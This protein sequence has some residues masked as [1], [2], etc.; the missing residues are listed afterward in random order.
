M[1]IDGAVVIRTYSS[2]AAANVAA[3]ILG[4]EGIETHIQK[5]DCGG[6]YPS[7]QMS[8]GVRLLVKPE[9]REVADRILRE[10]ESEESLQTEPPES[11]EDLERTKSSPFVVAGW[12]ILG[13]AIGFFVSFELLQRSGYN[14]TMKESYNAVG[15]P[16]RIV[17]YADGK[18]SRYEEDRNYDGKVDAWYTFTA[19]QPRTGTL[20]NN[21][22]GKP[23]VWIM[24]KDEFNYTE[25]MDTDYDG[26][27]DATIFHVN[28]MR[29]RVD[30]HPKDSPNIERTEL[31]E[32]DVLKEEL[33]DTDG[34]GIF[35][36]KITYDRYG[37]TIDKSK[38]WIPN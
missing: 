30:W 4:S 28:G 19:G 38:C 1:D 31:Y 2:D 21:F 33:I 9:D 23:D 18:L 26:K 29:H 3:S 13:F 24:Y 22:D 12:F 27:P 11:G 7:L 6:A 15:I 34:D 10:V 14:G 36:Q 32:H 25:R 5:N 17:H 35:D 8:E 37:R 20:D 16:G